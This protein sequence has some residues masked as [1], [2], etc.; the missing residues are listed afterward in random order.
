MLADELCIIRVR[1]KYYGIFCLVIIFALYALQIQLHV[2]WVMTHSTRQNAIAKLQDAMLFYPSLVLPPPPGPL[3][4]CLSCTM[5]PLLVQLIWPLLL[6][7]LPSLGERGGSDKLG[8]FSRIVPGQCGEDSMP[9]YCYHFTTTTTSFKLWCCNH[10]I[11]D[12]LS[13]HLCYYY[14]CRV[15]PRLMGEYTTPSPPLTYAMTLSCYIAILQPVCHVSSPCMAAANSLL[16]GHPP[17]LLGSGP[18]FFLFALSLP[19]HMR[20][21]LY[22]DDSNGKVWSIIVVYALKHTGLSSISVLF[23]GIEYNSSGWASSSR[24]FVWHMDH[25]WGWGGKVFSSPFLVPQSLW[26]PSY[27]PWIHYSCCKVS[28]WHTVN[29]FQ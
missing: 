19:C 7:W 28:G 21:P 6:P 16:C 2:I 22:N 25:G 29:I 17:P 24:I 14:H 9:F 11:V 10:S 13:G 12:Y 26:E 5:P 15:S 8:N 20:S 4:H 3:P 23:V 1:M 18:S 27:P